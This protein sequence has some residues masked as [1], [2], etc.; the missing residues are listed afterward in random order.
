[1]VIKQ[2]IKTVLLTA[3]VVAAG[4]FLLWRPQAVTSGISRGLSVCGGVLIPSLFPFLVLSGFLTRSGVAD[5]IGRRLEGV[6]RLLFGLPGCCAAGILI[7]A[8]GGYPTGGAVVGELVR[9]GQI[10]R[11]EGRRMLRFCVNGGPGFIIS[12]VGAGLM[13]SVQVGMILFFAHLAASWLMGIVS[14]PRG[15]RRKNE[16]RLIAAPPLTTSVAF[17]ESVTG[18]CRSTVY[19]CGFVVLFSA[20][21]ALIDAV[22]ITSFLGATPQG[23]R[24]VSALLACVLEVG[25]GCTAAASLGENAILLLGFSVGF[26]GLSV[27]CQLAASLQWLKLIDS[28]FFLS[29]LAHGL[30]TAFLATTAYRY[31]PLSQSVWGPMQTPIMQTTSGSVTLSVALLVL[32]GVWM[33]VVPCHLDKEP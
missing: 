22:N 11:E 8:I 7:S 2:R 17:V 28:A 5:A 21:T 4:V 10:T 20:I 16:K 3:T 19:M 14:A 32:S 24:L 1:M 6:T 13:G 31:I 9:R 12:A 25:G 27:L 18:A 26:G 15:S 30:L 23:D 29:R 33:L